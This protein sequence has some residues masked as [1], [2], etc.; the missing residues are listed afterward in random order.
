MAFADAVP[1]VL[2]LQDVARE[3]RL[4]VIGHQAGLEYG[5]GGLDIVG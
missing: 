1:L 5:V 2:V 4:M 3:Q